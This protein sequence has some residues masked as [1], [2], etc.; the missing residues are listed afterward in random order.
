[1]NAYTPYLKFLSGIVEQTYFTFLLIGSVFALLAGLMLLFDSQKAFRIGD[2]LDRW[3]S[4]RLA[5]R[6]LMKQ[7][8]ISR[9]LYRMHRVVG[10][11]F[12]VGALYSLVV[13]GMPS[14]EATIAK[15]LRGIGT[16]L[17][18]A[19]L[20]D[21]LRIF[22]LVGN[23]AVLLVGL[24]FTVRPSALKSLEAWTDRSISTRKATKPLEEL[25]R[26]ADRFARAHPR[27]VGVLTILG[28]LYVLANLGYTLLR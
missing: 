16:P 5:M 3:V 13:L 12:C 8:S 14:G 10:T 18:S 2:W 23:A 11:L 17:V 1:M 15:S 22:L 20:S 4:T 27:L 19:W 28:S 7:Y 21:S 25:H 26:P 9:P 24:V 6:P